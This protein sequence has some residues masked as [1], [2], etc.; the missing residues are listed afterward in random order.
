MM[1]DAYMCMGADAAWEGM[2]ANGTLEARASDLRF[3]DE[4]ARA[5]RDRPLDN[6]VV[7]EPRNRGP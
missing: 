7:S 1:C 3:V 6:C 4:I 2:G 5:G